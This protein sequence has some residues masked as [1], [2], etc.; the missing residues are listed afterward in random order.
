M[1]K[2]TVFVKTDS[3]VSEVQ[4][5]SS[6]LYGDVKRI[7]L[8][9][10]DKSNVG[11][12]TK[13]APPSLRETLPEVLQILLEDGYIKDGNAPISTAQK[14]S[15]KI[16]SPA[17][18]MSTPKDAATGGP[19]AAKSQPA[20][21]NNNSSKSDLDFSFISSDASQ[22]KAEADKVKE[23]AL[24]EAK[25]FAEA[26]AKAQAEAE[27]KAKA[28]AQADAKI[29]AEN[30]AKAK[31]EAD[32]LK[33]LQAAQIEAASKA[34]K[35]KAY[36]EA[37][38]R[39]RNEVAAKAKIEVEARLK[40]DAEVA[41]R[42]AEQ[43][44]LTARSELEVT[45][46]RVEAEVRSRIEA[47]V[48]VKQEIEAANLKAKQEA[49][50]LRL[51]LE[52]AKAQAEAEL[53]NR[54]EAEARVK[55]EVE[56][57]IKR[58]A[59]AEHL[60]IEKERAEKE[61]ARAKAEAEIKIRTEAELRVRAEVEARLKAEEED[62]L[63]REME[64]E[65]MKL[66]RERAEIELARGKAEAELK[67]RTEAELRIRAE[68]EARMRAEEVAR[69]GDRRRASS[70]TA[71]G[72]RGSDIPSLEEQHEQAEMLKK[73]FVESFNQSKAK[74]QKSSLFNFKLDTFSLSGKWKKA[75]PSL[76]PKGV[77]DSNAGDDMGLKAQQEAEARRIKDE[78][79]AA[80][81][82][83]EQEAARRSAEQEAYRLQAEQNERQA[84]ADAEARELAGQ[85]ARQWEEAQRRASAQ[86]ERERLD[87]EAAAVQAKSRQKVNRA[88]RKPIPVGKILLGIFA[89][90]LIVVAALPYVWQYDEYIAPMEKEISA[91]LN[92]PVRIKKIHF[93]LLPMPKLELSGL[94]VGEKQELQV[95]EA[96]L[97]FSL[98]ALLSSTRPINRIVLN[99]ISLNSSSF[100]QSVGW[101]Q[102]AG[103]NEKYPVA[104]MEL[105]GVTVTSDEIKLPQFNVQADF[106]SQGK[107][108]R[109]EL[110]SDDGKFELE[111][112]LLQKRLQLELKAHES[113]LPVFPHVKFKD[114]SVTGVI[115]N[116]DFIVSDIFAHIYG[117]TLTG[118]GQ[119]SWING[120]KL[121]GQ[122]LSKSL[123]LQNLFPNYGVTGELFGDFN[124]SMYGVKLSQLD[125]DMR[126][127]GNFEAKNGVISKLDIDSIARFGARQGVAG[128]RS[129]FSQLAGTF[130]ADNRG[131]RIY[132]NKMLIG[133]VSG[134][135]LFEVDASQQLTG[136]LSVNI[137]A[138]PGKSVP[139]LLSGSLKEPQLQSG[140]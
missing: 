3:G 41:R 24:A 31:L 119:L 122:L 20:K 99:K 77:E 70:D 101:L 57:R 25:V 85:Q 94:Y 102:S 136:K 130:K 133:V 7:L 95:S 103:G 128:S 45:K 123:E 114:L 46:A 90:V 67:M 47:E 49:E 139:L 51:E 108:V 38:E 43:E 22:D 110:K 69:N 55:A 72:S 87:K 9:V 30:A 75:D 34:A 134:S 5:H 1:E 104:R 16:S 54:L 127:E 96:A 35:I 117:G 106:D 2:K 61:A 78:Q 6:E 115:E 137:S 135:G 50:K 121:Q 124:F 126:L 21:S 86:A 112:Q 88:P 105:Q 53:K 97:H 138:V 29:Q 60:K 56:A 10:D 11:D 19:V 81:I 48:R 15:L 66:E 113:S 98:S 52:A 129:N 62:R 93:A 100:G 82:K 32:R 58:E 44:V 107:F 74:Q 37:K 118:K 80:R 65:R 33:A 18:K 36:E 17:F 76:V 8:L 116:G 109:A 63:K 39:A 131:Q 13:R 23:R 28:K 68:V 111:M 26:K 14:S 83:A 91:Q 132:L 4:G 120:W 71:T 92:Q 64:T 84:K 73:S 89:L 12:I 59:E 42:R 125:K 27:A 40:N 140:R 79:E